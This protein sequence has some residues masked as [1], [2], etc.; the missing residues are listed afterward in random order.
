MKWLF[1]CIAV[2][3]LAEAAE[4]TLVRM[5]QVKPLPFLIPPAAA[6]PLMCEPE[7]ECCKCPVG[8]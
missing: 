5:S 8:L 1:I 7:P 6:T 2:C 3:V 4:S